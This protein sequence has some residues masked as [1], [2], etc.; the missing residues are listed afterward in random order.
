MSN[1]FRVKSGLLLDS[2]TTTKTVQLKAP[3][4]ISTSLTLTLPST[5]PASETSPLVVDSSGNITQTTSPYLTSPAI[6]TSMLLYD[7]VGSNKITMQSAAM[8]GDYTVTWPA[9]LPGVGATGML[10]T[11]ENGALTWTAPITDHTA[12]TNLTGGTYSDGGH[13]NLVQYEGDTRDPIASDDTAAYKLGA[14]WLNT[15]SKRSFVNVDNGSGAAVWGALA[16]NNAANNL[17]KTYSHTFTLAANTVGPVEPAFSLV[18]GSTVFYARI[19]VI[20]IDPTDQDRVSVLAFDAVGGRLDA[21]TPLSIAV[22]SISQVST[23]ANVE[24]SNDIATTATDIT[25]TKT[26]N[27][28]T[29]NYTLIVQAEVVNGT[30]EE[31][32]DV[33]GAASIK[34]FAY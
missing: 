24:L 13:T 33:T 10:Q 32:Y 5:L 20:A 1:Y 7:P 28:V 17:T 21:G 27:L 18:F 22:G 30:L 26:L 25:L 15:T 14:M 11:D 3:S 12:L 8:T 2:A 23:N 16:F 19:K 34:A 4:G 9:A 6:H 29:G 31:L